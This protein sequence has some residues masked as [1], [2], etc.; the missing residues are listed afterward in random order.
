MRPFL[1]L[2]GAAVL[3]LAVLAA[4]PAEI[5]ASYAKAAGSAP[6][7]ERG[8][9]LFTTTQGREWSCASCHKEL[10]TTAGRHARTGKTIE[11]LAP[12]GNPDRFTDPAR[13]EKW[14]RRNCND[15]L[16]RECS[17]QEKAD[18]TYWLATLKR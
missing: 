1:V 17:A 5:S 16:G 6:S 18:V 13:V 4:T 7:A 2:L 10:P 11:P 15:V 8:R 9:Q 3:P 12:A 14:L